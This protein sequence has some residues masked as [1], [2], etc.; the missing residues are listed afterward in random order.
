V[1]E[2]SLAAYVEGQERLSDAIRTACDPGD[3]LPDKVG[4]ALAAAFSLFAVDP[5][6]AYL[7]TISPER[8]G[9]DLRRLQWEWRRRYGSLLRD[10]AA[11]DGAPEPRSFSSRC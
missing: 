1:S 5:G 6:L 11:E 3:P 2:A 8:A 7:L 4:T 10:A 9:D